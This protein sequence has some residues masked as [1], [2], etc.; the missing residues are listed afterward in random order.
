M[1]DG[2]VLQYNAKKKD[3]PVYTFVALL[4]SGAI[5]EVVAESY[6]D[7][8]DDEGNQ[9]FYRWHKNKHIVLE[10]PADQVKAVI[11]NENENWEDII[12]AVQRKPRSRKK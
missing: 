11:S 2:R 10:L 7:M 6:A 9:I 8:F 5:L 4:T 12:K 1:T 3:S